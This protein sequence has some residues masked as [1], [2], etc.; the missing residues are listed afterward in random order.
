[1]T[2]ATDYELFGP[3]DLQGGGHVTWTFTG[4]KAAEFRARVIH[5]FDEYDIIPTGFSAAGA[6]IPRNRD[7][8]LDVAEG[9]VYTDMLEVMLERKPLGTSVQYMTLFPFDLRREIRAIE[10]RCFS[11]VLRASRDRTSTRR[12]TP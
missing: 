1:M 7:G 9:L 2:V 11:G 8:K 3:S 4:S 6:P 10:P 5:M 12:R